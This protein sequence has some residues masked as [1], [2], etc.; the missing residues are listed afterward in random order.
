[1]RYSFG[2]NKIADYALQV[3][4]HIIRCIKAATIGYL[5]RLVNMPKKPAHMVSKDILK[6]N[7]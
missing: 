1:M 2:L 7:L 4:G 6:I 5:P 3:S